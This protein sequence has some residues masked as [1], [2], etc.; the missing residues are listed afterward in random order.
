MRG[1]SHPVVPEPDEPSGRPVDLGERRGSDPQPQQ[2]GHGSR[3]STSRSK[4][5]MT[6]LEIDSVQSGP[7]TFSNLLRKLS[8]R[9]V[10]WI[11]VTVLVTTLCFAWVRPV[12]CHDD[13]EC[14]RIHRDAKDLNI[15]SA[16][17][18][19]AL[20]SVFLHEM[21]SVILTYRTAQ[22]AIHLI[23]NIKESLVPSALLCTTFAVLLLENIPFFI[24]ESP[25]FAHAANVGREDLDH[26]PVY[27]I[28]FADPWHPKKDIIVQVVIFGYI[29]SLCA[30][31]LLGHLNTEGGKTKEYRYERRFATC[32]HCSLDLDDKFKPKL[33]HIYTHRQLFALLPSPQE[34]RKLKRPD[35]V[36]CFSRFLQ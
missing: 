17:I 23:P 4:L 24:G 36:R 12:A 9:K 22:K 28:F 35:A 11:I 15:Y 33:I 6:D 25:W 31:F 14:S 8:I 18:A 2:V 30:C 26:L 21:V 32:H 16:F 34:R 20:G 5:N 1:G 19:A 29:W 3:R 7:D 10:T 27:T 13:S